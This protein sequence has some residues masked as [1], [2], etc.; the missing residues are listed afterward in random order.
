MK[1]NNKSDYYHFLVCLE[2]LKSDKADKA[3][4]DKCTSGILAIIKPYVSKK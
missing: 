3:E 4:K 2:A 1:K